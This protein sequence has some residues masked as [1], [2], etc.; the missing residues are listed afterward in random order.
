MFRALLRHLVNA[1]GGSTQQS[2]YIE[3]GDGGGEEA[4]RCKDREAAANVRWYRERLYSFSSRYLCQIAFFRVGGEDQVFLVVALTQ[5]LHE[6]ATD[7]EE[8]GHRLGGRPALGDDVGPGSAQVGDVQDSCQSRGIGVLGEVETR[9]SAV[10]KQ[11]IVR[12]VQG[13]VNG[14]GT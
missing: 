4:H 1:L 8:V 13:T 6:S 5:G 11:V 7:D 10:G 2:V 9:P 14:D 12:V 3:A